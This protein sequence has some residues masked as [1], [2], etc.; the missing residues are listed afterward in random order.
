MER[1]R[2]A[3]CCTGD[4]RKAMPRPAAL[5]FKR[6]L[7]APGHTEDEYQALRYELA[8]AFEQ[9]LSEQA[10]AQIQQIL[11]QRRLLAGAQ[12]VRAVETGRS[13]TA[14]VRHDHAATRR[15]RGSH[16][17]DGVL[18]QVQAAARRRHRIGRQ[19]AVRCVR[20]DGIARRSCHRITE[21]VARER[22]A[23]AGGRQQRRQGAA[24]R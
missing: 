17:V 24:L 3:S 12:C 1:A 22:V 23:V 4:L 6:G 21:R 11:R 8:S 10:Q 15:C 14:K 16:T 19:R 7:E 20:A 5:W 9:F 18:A 13:V 2:S